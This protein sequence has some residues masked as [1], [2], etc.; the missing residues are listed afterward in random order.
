MEWF[1]PVMF[2]VSF[3]VVYVS[4]RKDTK[5]NSMTKKGFYKLLAFL[6]VIFLISFGAAYFIQ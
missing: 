6:V 1:F 5:G 3:A 4:L 2:L